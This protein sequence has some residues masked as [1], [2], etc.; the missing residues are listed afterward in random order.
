MEM[1]GGIGPDACIDAVGMESHGFAID[2]V[3]DTVK[4][5]VGLGTDRPHALRQVIMA[6]RKGGR[7]RSP[8]S[9]AACA[10]SSRSA[11]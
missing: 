10:T 9:T 6:C 7:S 1:T 11:R 2:N 8:A 5:S 3:V 4:A